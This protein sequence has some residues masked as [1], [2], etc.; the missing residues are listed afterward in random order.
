MKKYI[1]MMYVNG[2]YQLIPTV[3]TL[4]LSISTAKSESQHKSKQNQIPNTP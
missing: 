1:I 4:R 2:T 3:V